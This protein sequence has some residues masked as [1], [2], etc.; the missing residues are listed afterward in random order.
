[1]KFAFEW[2][3]YEIKIW[4]R[5]TCRRILYVWHEDI[6]S[7]QFNSIHKPGANGCNIVGQQIPN[8]V[9]CYML[10]PYA[11]LVA[12]SC[13]LLGVVVHSLKLVKFLA[14]LKW[15]Q[16]LPKLLCPFAPGYSLQELL[17]HATHLFRNPHMTI[18]NFCHFWLNSVTEYQSYPDLFRS[19]LGNLSNWLRWGQ[20]ECQKSS[21]FRFA[22]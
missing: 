10:R 16:Q 15:I 5:G 18:P 3:V 14:T 21:S 11:H 17:S 13:V 2:W 7:V 22:K 6:S 4:N 9:G 19:A 12:C 1:M 20:Q 8:I